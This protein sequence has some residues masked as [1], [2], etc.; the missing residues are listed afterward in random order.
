[1]ISPTFPVEYL[2]SAIWEPECEKFRD[3]LFKLFF[4]LYIDQ[5][6]LE[7]VS[8]PLLIRFIGD[9]DF[10]NATY[11]GHI[12]RELNLDD[13][14]PKKA[15]VDL[16]IRVVND[17][18]KRVNTFVE[19]VTSTV[20]DRIVDCKFRKEI[21]V[22]DLPRPILESVDLLFRLL[23]LNV[24]EIF[25][26]YDQY[27]SILQIC[28]KIFDF[29]QMSPAQFV[30]LLEQRK[31]E[32]KSVKAPKQS[33]KKKKGGSLAKYT[34]L[35]EE[36]LKKSL[37]SV[38]Y[39]LLK[40]QISNPLTFA[41]YYPTRYDTLA[42][43]LSALVFQK[44]MDL[45]QQFLLDNC[46]EWIRSVSTKFAGKRFS[47]A[48]DDLLFDIC[49]KEAWT[50]F[51]PAFKT[52]IA[53]AD[54]TQQKLNFIRYIRDKPEVYDLP[55]LMKNPPGQAPQSALKETENF[56]TSLLVAIMT[57]GE[58]DLS[59][60]LMN[61]L[62]A[63]YSQR[64]R[65]MDCLKAS[66]QLSSETGI[67]IYQIAKSYNK[68][69][70]TM[71]EKISNWNR[72]ESI[73][74][75]SGPIIE[76]LDKISD[77][78]S[79]N[80]VLTTPTIHR[81]SEAKVQDILYQGG[82]HLMI[83]KLYK[84]LVDVFNTM[85]ESKK[86]TDKHL[87]AMLLTIMQRCIEILRLFIKDNLPM[88][89]NLSKYIDDLME[90]SRYN[91]GQ[92]DLISDL[93]SD[94]PTIKFEEKKQIISY[95]VD[96]IV[97]EG[98]QTRFLDFFEA[99]L[100]SRRDDHTSVVSLVLDTFLPY[101]QPKEHS[102]S[103]RLIYGMMNVVT[104]EHEMNLNDDIEA[105]KEDIGQN[106][107]AFK[108]EPFLFHRRLLKIYLRLL[109][110]NLENLV[111]LRLRKYFSLSYLIRLLSEKDCFFDSRFENKLQ[112]QALTDEIF[113]IGQDKE[114]RRR[115][116]VTL[117]K[118]VLSELL[119]RIHCHGETNLYRTIVPSLNI[120]TNLI[121]TENDRI[122]NLGGKSSSEFCDFFS[123]LVKSLVKMYEMKTN[124][125]FDKTE[126]D[127]QEFQILIILSFVNHDLLA[128][129]FTT[130]E[131][132]R[133]EKIVAWFEDE[134][135]TKT[136]ESIRE[137]LL[138]PE[139][140]WV[141]ALTN[142]ALEQRASEIKLEILTIEDVWQVAVDCV[143]QQAHAAIQN[144]NDVFALSLHSFDNLFDKDLREKFGVSFKV[145]DM[146]LKM[147]QFLA[148]E[149][150]EL[151]KKSI[152]LDFL[153]R[154]IDKAENREDCQI[155]L[156]RNGFSKTVV[157]LLAESEFK[158]EEFSRKLVDF[159][160]ALLLPG[161]R[162]IQR[163]L[164]SFFTSNAVSTG[165]LFQHIDNFIGLFQKV[166]KDSH[167]TKGIKY[168]G[169]LELVERLIEWLRLL[170]ENH[171]EDAQ[172][173]LRSQ[174]NLRKRVNFLETV[175]VLLKQCSSNPIN[176]VY[177]LFLTSINFLVEMLQ[178]PCVP[179]QT[180]LIDLNL[181]ATLDRIL[182]WQKNP[183][184]Y[185]KQIA[186]T[187]TITHKSK[188][189]RLKLAK[190][191]EE[192]G[193]FNIAKIEESL[194]GQYR[195]DNGMIATLKYKAIVLLNSMLESLSDR[196]SLGKIKKEVSY[197]A[198]K[199]LI[200][201]V[202]VDFHDRYQGNYFIES[203][204]HY[205][206]KF[207]KTLKE[208]ERKKA[209]GF[210]LETGFLTLFIILKLYNRKTEPN[211]DI[212]ADLMKIR[213]KMKYYQ[214][215]G[216]VNKSL[217]SSFKKDETK[218]LHLDKSHSL[219]EPEDFI[220]RKDGSIFEE[221]I[222][223][224]YF[225]SSK[226]EIFRDNK[227]QEIYFIKLPYCEYLDDADKD[228]FNHEVDRSTTLNKVKGLIDEVDYFTVIMKF[229]YYLKTINFVI[230]IVFNYQGFYTALSFFTAVAI[231]IL[232]MI[233]YSTKDTL[234]FHSNLY[235]ASL[236]DDLDYSTTLRVIRAV[237]YLQL[238]I[239]IRFF[240]FYLMKVVFMSHNSKEY[241]YNVD[242]LEGFKL[243][244]YRI[245]YFVLNRN[246]FYYALYTT[247]A[248][249]GILMHPFFF[250]FHLYEV[251][252]QFKT[253]RI[254][255][256]S[257]I[258]PYKQLILAFIFYN[259]LI[260]EYAVLGYYFFWRWFVDAKPEDSFSVGNYCDSLYMCYITVFDQTNKEPGG[261]GSH[262]DFFNENALFED[263]YRALYDITFRLVVPIIMLSIVKGI[264]VDTFGALRELEQDKTTDMESRCFICG[265]E[266]DSFDKIQTKTFV[267][268]IKES[269]NMWDYVHFLTFINQKSKTELTG[270]EYYV[271]NHYVR[272]KYQWIP[273][274][275]CLE[276]DDT[277]EN[278]VNEKLNEKVEVL[279]QNVERM[280]KSYEHV[281][282]SVSRY[283]QGI[284]TAK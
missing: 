194:Q 109:D 100:D 220:S 8:L 57:T 163:S 34:G 183:E 256:Q 218:I 165:Q 196:L 224:F 84:K 42:T 252:N 162:T 267:E 160:I 253:C 29:N 21:T 274:K 275:M 80:Q 148:N 233:S 101:I 258:L 116:G 133:L 115:I 61:L 205:D 124:S 49:E 154:F 181:I 121:W 164:Y 35:D 50:I 38:N 98:N 138:Q 11:D 87:A 20:I 43:K 243:F 248:L 88:K 260:Y 186:S 78:L 204:N 6:P 151:S 276:I 10:Q 66:F 83:I 176:K 136:F 161:N 268:H 117:L 90:F 45:R 123:Y 262:L 52:M 247:A 55:H 60:Q 142:T 167:F 73:L 24:L 113:D 27:S 63:I 105:F 263:S 228:M 111:K 67:S 53:K 230:R 197:R 209:E 201:E 30:F 22:P 104:E 217:I 193:E 277:E 215:L 7:E 272:G 54:I 85:D 79:H 126:T 235:D 23:K 257:I 155:L 187:L 254:F 206:P 182:R 225:Y 112:D 240:I 141:D 114:E 214:K 244:K 93:F 178:G 188:L 4:N 41:L 238:S 144:E 134:E 156:D 110:S 95:Y 16:I 169:K 279:K 232:V 132:E 32:N 222:N 192:A 56:F 25:E 82:C 17:L 149:S 259:I 2:V 195:M 203:L 72:N 239:G 245:S 71:L 199:K 74:I 14:Y 236:A 81:R 120:L 210:I 234:N 278:D 175:S 223:F 131:L 284:V 37:L 94:N 250:A 13:S 191:L 213:E 33:K 18:S 270:E 271:Y 97:A 184:G 143:H 282:T 119:Y 273:N 221:A 12:R 69:I 102:A 280:R 226:I 62:L 118:P 174:P 130:H 159:L 103:I 177:P 140:I 237:G 166:V 241:K 47:Q 39:F 281:A 96:K 40:N 36:S 266:R 283:V 89:K 75:E 261:I 171:F 211:E 15:L 150:I 65:L 137:Y 190:R 125:L 26:L 185:R 219:V 59:I 179:N 145:T 58:E 129:S 51:P 107:I 172:E 231:N 46:T 106:I 128:G 198:L 86:L 19:S 216:F 152:C 91:V 255:I 108:C 77:K 269:H 64:R 246:I 127:Q 249:L 189:L 68:E 242:E 229:A 173:Y 9:F 99:I 202:Y 207:M 157:A 147:R 212:K 227:I 31:K 70:T 135:A 200:I 5:A 208:K 170:C 122:K 265:I 158:N 44:F 1:M 28:H 92:S 48:D 146:L 139:K 3:I 264:I 251:M 168:D 76:L 153:I 180:S